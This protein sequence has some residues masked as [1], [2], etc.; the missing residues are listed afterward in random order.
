MPWDKLHLGCG[1]TIPDGWLNVD[2]SLNA[3]AAKFPLLR[4]SLAAVGL[5]SKDT[6]KVRWGSNVFHHDVRKPLPWPEGSFRAVYASHLLEHLHLGEGRRLLHECRRV[7]RVGGVLRIVVPDLRAAA[8]DY[9][10]GRVHPLTWHPEGLRIG[11]CEEFNLRVMYHETE[12]PGGGLI[13]RSYRLHNAFHQ[14]KWMYDEEAVLRSFADAGFVDCARRGF[15]ESRIAEVK[16]VEARDRVE[17]GGLVVEGVR[18][19]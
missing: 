2:G 10:A 13:L 4:R 5:I 9:L 8:A 1:L 12:P 18:G 16:D 19:A 3:R 6:A 15:L 17:D 11:P 14:H 7:L